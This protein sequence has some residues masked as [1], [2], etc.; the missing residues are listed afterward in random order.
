VLVDRAGG[1]D[2]CSV[3]VDDVEGGLLAV[4]HLIEQGHHRIAFIGGP[5]IT[6]QVADR[7]T[8]A[9]S[10]FEAAGRSG[11]DLVVLPTE[12]MN[13]AEGQRAGERLLG[14]PRAR[15]PTAAFCAN[16]LVALGL[17][18]QMTR[19]GADVP[20]DLAIVGYDD[21][22]FA[23][24]AAV[25]LSSVRQPRELLG[26]TAAELLLAESKDVE[27]HVHQQVVFHPELVVRTSSL[28]RT[29]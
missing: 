19:S 23:G 2:W 8:G 14:L 27:A 26:R 12:T 10:A 15:R 21:I 3:G 25:P 9:R 20:G 29:D 1:D 5:L 24:A 6:V 17:L 7:L 28:S 16:D 11:D 22:A 13:F 4:T 18:Q